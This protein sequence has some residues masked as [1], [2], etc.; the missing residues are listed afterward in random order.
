M[1]YET[2]ALLCPTGNQ[3]IL[4]PTVT[5]GWKIPKVMSSTMLTILLSKESLC[6]RT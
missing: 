1:R 3:S 2:L 4:E 6:L 5:F